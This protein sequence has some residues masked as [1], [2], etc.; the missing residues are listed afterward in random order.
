MYHQE[1]SIGID[2]NP[3]T[4]AD[5]AVDF[6]ERKQAGLRAMLNKHGKDLSGQISDINFMEMRIDLKIPM[7]SLATFESPSS[8]PGVSN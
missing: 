3:V 5:I 8:K 1:K 4:A 2:E 6:H 7:P